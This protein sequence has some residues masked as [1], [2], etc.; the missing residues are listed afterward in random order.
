MTV[1]QIIRESFSLLCKRH[2]W[3]LAAITVIQM[4]TGFLDLAGVLLL[5]LVSV[6]SVAALS[7]L[8]LPDSVQSFVDRLGWGG[9]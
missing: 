5:G 7:G 3:M 4:A 6:L 2:K 8:A 1:I 9:V